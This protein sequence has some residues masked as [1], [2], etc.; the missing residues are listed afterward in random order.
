MESIRLLLALASQEGWPV[1]HMDAK[2]AFL[3]GELKE[4]VYVKQSPGFIVTGEEGEVLRLRK[5]LYGLR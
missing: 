4:E 1:H 3:N 5:A 2:S